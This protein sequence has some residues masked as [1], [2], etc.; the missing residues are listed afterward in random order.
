MRSTAV[1]A[2]DG[3]TGFSAA[4]AAIDYFDDGLVHNHNWAASSHDRPASAGF[5]GMPAASRFRAYDMVQAHE[6][7]DDGLVHNHDWAVG[8][9]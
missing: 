3:M 2:P 4:R 9:K 8:G 5:A 6:R 1:Y 7:F